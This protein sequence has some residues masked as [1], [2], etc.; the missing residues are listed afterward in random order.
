MA[1]R[2]NALKPSG[3]RSPSMSLRK[4]AQHEELTNQ[5]EDLLGAFLASAVV[6]G[7]AVYVKRDQRRG[8]II[9]KLYDGDDSYEDW[10]KP[11]ELTIERLDDYAGQLGFKA[12]YRALVAQSRFGAKTE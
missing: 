6:G 10:L 5:Q 1:P 7:V 3:D 12:H 2:K 9:L 4:E 11:D 8:A